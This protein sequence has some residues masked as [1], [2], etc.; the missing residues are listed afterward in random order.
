MNRKINDKSLPDVQGM[1]DS[2]VSNMEAIVNF[3]ENVVPVVTEYDEKISKTI[4]EAKQ[5]II[6]I[7]GPKFEE[8]QD[9][10][11]NREGQKDSNK[12]RVVEEAA[13]G[14]IQILGKYNR[15]P[16]M[17]IGQVELL[18]RSAFVLLNAFLDYLIHDVISCY[19]ES[20]PQS[21]SEKDKELTIDL[22]SLSLCS[23]IDDAVDMIIEK[24]VDSITY[25][26]LM[27]QKRFLKEHLSL[28]LRESVVNWDIINEAVERRNVIIHNECVVNRRYLRSVELTVIPEGKRLKEGDKVVVNSEYFTKVHGEIFMAG[29]LIAQSCWR[30]W[31]KE[32]LE[33]ADASLIRIMYSQLLEEKWHLVEKLGYASKDMETKDVASRWAIDINYCQAL[34]WQGKEAEL[35]KE[36]SAIDESSLNPKLKACLAALRGNRDDFYKYAEQAVMV[37]ELDNEAFDVWPLF[38]ELRQDAEYKDRIKAILSRKSDN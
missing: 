38:R 14:V 29:V 10:D 28:D 35:Q 17:D 25:K 11:S 34:K 3:V 15:L 9:T 27:E 16:R 32:E 6:K 20:Y 8:K 19:Y 12:E 31:Q 36:I 13:E 22:S 26:N 5:K 7:L 2:F 23:D 21:L 4:E 33:E 18:Y 30:K 24:K 1:Q 37:D